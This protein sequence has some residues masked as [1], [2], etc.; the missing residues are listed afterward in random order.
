MKQDI[1]Y[2]EKKTSKKEILVE[3][4]VKIVELHII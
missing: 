2:Y 4:I 3:L 1:L